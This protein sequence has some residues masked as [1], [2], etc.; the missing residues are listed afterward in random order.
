[1]NRRGIVAVAASTAV[2]A[3][4]VTAGIAHARSSDEGVPPGQ[5]KGMFTL[6]VTPNNSV[7]STVVLACDPTDGN[8]PHPAEAC[9]DLAKVDGQIANIKPTQGEMC[10]H[11]VAPVRATAVGRWG[12]TPIN[13][14]HTFPNACE[15][16][17]ATGAVFAFDF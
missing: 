10:P 7:Q 14:D 5:P 8:H 6:G 15:M 1:V 13:Y 3:G 4:L 11:Y 9:A 12:S 17:R 2:I 16:R